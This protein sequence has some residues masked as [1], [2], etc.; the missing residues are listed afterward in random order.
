MNKWKRFDSKVTGGRKIFD[1]NKI[2]K[3]TVEAIA[4][5]TRVSERTIRDVFKGDIVIEQ[6]IESISDFK[7]TE[8]FGFLPDAPLM[9]KDEAAKYLNIKVAKLIY[10]CKINQIPFFKLKGSRGSK[11]LF[12]QRDLDYILEKRGQYVN[13]PYGSFLA[14]GAIK[15]AIKGFLESG[16]L[17]EKYTK[18]LIDVVINDKNSRE[19]SASEGLTHQAIEERF[20]VGLQKL[21][22]FPQ[23]IEFITKDIK[24]LRRENL[25][26]KERVRGFEGDNN[27]QTYHEENVG[28]F[29][30]VC[31]DVIDLDFTVRAINAFGYAEIKTVRHLLEIPVINL[32]GSR[33]I[34][35][36]TISD[37]ELTVL[38]YCG[39]PLNRNGEKRNIT[40]DNINHFVINK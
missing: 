36:K 4:N 34:G 6:D 23:Q 27:Q 17:S 7:V 19:I 12:L 15:T 29:E 3:V 10:L 35:L 32:F 40:M 33:N 28:L 1:N 30:K 18:V 9:K 13:L 24:R 8:K 39:I 2:S 37:I 25:I 14:T 26:L 11:L 38:A 22:R 21:R 5:I 16:I 31:A 20:R